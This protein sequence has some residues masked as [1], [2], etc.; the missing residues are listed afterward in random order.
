M[1]KLWLWDRVGELQFMLLSHTW[2][3]LFLQAPHIMPVG[4]TVL[5][6]ESPSRAHREEGDQGVR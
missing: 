3:L 1:R 6:S 2:A 4:G 5:I